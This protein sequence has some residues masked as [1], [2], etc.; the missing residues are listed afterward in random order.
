MDRDATMD[1]LRLEK[2][3][4][5]APS[6]HR[7]TADSALAC[8]LKS[9]TC[10]IDPSRFRTSGA[11]RCHQSLSNKSCK[12]RT[13]TAVRARAHTRKRTLTRARF[14]LRRCMHATP[15]GA[16]VHTR[17]LVSSQ[18]G[19][20]R[21]ASRA[22]YCCSARRHVYNAHRAFEAYSVHNAHQR[23]LA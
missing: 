23:S 12:R 20:S 11:D 13:R 7:V 10:A 4:V 2:V 18:S 1:T 21:C 8:A 6:R 22:S 5:T 19:S 15:R 17:C 3:P 16:L 9:R 14:H